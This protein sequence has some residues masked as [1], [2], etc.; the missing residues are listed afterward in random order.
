MPYT[1]SGFM[2]SYSP[3]NGTGGGYS[4]PEDFAG[5]L[6]QLKLVYD[7]ASVNYKVNV[8]RL[9]GGFNKLTDAEKV[10]NLIYATDLSG[11]IW[12]ITMPLLVAPIPDFTITQDGNCLKKFVF[13]NQSVNEPMTYLWNFGDGTTSTETNPTHQYA[14]IGDYTVTL[15]AKNPQ[16][17]I[18]KNIM[19]SIQNPLLITSPI[20]GNANFIGVDRIQATNIINS[21]ANVLYKTNKYILM[22][23]GFRINMGAKFLASIGGC[24]N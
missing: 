9:I 24:D 4:P 11:N 16:G 14:N 15:S 12:K 8:T 21:G 17:I 2:L 6:C 19:V 3:E 1:G 10:R 5:D 7:Q 20:T 13:Q 22:N 23:P 18:T